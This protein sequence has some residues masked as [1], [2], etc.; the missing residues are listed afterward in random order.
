MKAGFSVADITPELGIYLTGYGN[1][2]RLAEA[3]HS[4]LRTTAMVLADGDTE[5]AVVSMDWCGISE[6]LASDI[7]RAIHEATG[8]DL[9]PETDVD[10]I[11]V[12]VKEMFAKDNSAKVNDIDGVKID[13]PDRW[14]H[15]RK[16]NTEPI[17]RVYSEAQTMAQADELGK[18]LM[19]VVYDMQS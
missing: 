2:S 16:S 17:I 10:A 11:L 9:T 4:P 7:H 15:L 5:A 13:F 8:I 1:P 6:E 3:V 12:K 19:Q 14:V 18:K